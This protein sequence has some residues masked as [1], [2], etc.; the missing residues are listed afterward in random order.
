RAEVEP[1][2]SLRQVD[3]RDGSSGSERRNYEER[4]R[5]EPLRDLDPGRYLKRP[6]YPAQYDSHEYVDSG[7]GSTRDD[8]HVVQ[9]IEALRRESGYQD[10]RRNDPDRETPAEEAPG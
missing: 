6:H 9:K 10:D 3:A 5:R 2:Q 8:M 4:C 7:P 1:A